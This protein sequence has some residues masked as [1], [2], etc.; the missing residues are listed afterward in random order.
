MN[1]EGIPQLPREAGEC[2]VRYGFASVGDWVLRGSAW[3]LVRAKGRGVASPK[4]FAI[5][6]PK[7]AILWTIEI[8]GE[9]VRSA[10]KR[11]RIISTEYGWACWYSVNCNPLGDCIAEGDSGKDLTLREAKAICQRHA[12][13]ISARKEAAH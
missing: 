10:C 1:I 6:K 7:S 11:Y 3:E 2:V 5:A 9:Y 12:D 13:D 8:D 4:I